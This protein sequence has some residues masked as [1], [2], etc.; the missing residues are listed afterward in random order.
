M[1]SKRQSPESTPGAPALLPT[2]MPGTT[3]PAP[4]QPL[5]SLT[6][7]LASCAAGWCLVSDTIARTPCPCRRSCLGSYKT[8]AHKKPVSTDGNT[9]FVSD[10][11]RPLAAT[12]STQC[13]LC[14]SSN[15]L[16]SATSPHC[17]TRALLVS[18][19]LHGPPPCQLIQVV[20]NACKYPVFHSHV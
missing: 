12:Q 7:D 4:D 6:Y 8:S 2:P 10:F 14:L 16:R 5:P 9:P 20:L 18:C 11:P 15:A 19:S 3:S 17:N 13:P 1:A